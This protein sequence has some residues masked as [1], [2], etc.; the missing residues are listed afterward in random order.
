MHRVGAVGHAPG[1]LQALA[2][3]EAG[4]VAQ[5]VFGFVLHGADGGIAVIALRIHFARAEKNEI[6]EVAGEQAQHPHDGVDADAAMFVHQEDGGGQFRIEFL[7]QA[8]FVLHRLAEQFFRLAQ[9]VL[10][11]VIVLADDQA[12]R[13]PPGW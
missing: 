3:A 7:R 9:L 5:G 1:G 2:A 13:R 12:Q 8:G 11:F 10:G 4:V 6:L